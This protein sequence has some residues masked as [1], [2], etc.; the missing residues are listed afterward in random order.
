M[1]DNSE[2]INRVSEGTIDDADRT[3]LEPAGHIEPW[4]RLLF[5]IQDTALVV[6][7]CASFRVKWDPFDGF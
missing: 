4:Y 7:D 3:A 2:G 1:L 6:R 5:L